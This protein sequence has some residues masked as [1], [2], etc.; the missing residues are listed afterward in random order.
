MDG[1]KALRAEKAAAPPLL[2]NAPVL[3]GNNAIPAAAADDGGA[4][5]AARTLEA[6][7]VERIR[8]SF[9]AVVRGEGG[10]A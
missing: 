6:S 1:R 4:A 2:G 3:D 9:K 5:S 10:R 8:S 7:D